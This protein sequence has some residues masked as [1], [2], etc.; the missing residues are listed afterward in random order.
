V[1]VLALGGQ[2]TQIGDTLVQRFLLLIGC[3]GLQHIVDDPVDHV[4]LGNATIDV[5]AFDLVVQ[6]TFH[7]TVHGHDTFTVGGLQLQSDILFFGLDQQQLTFGTPLLLLFGIDGIG[8]LLDAG[9][10][11]LLPVGFDFLEEELKV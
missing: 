4:L 10:T 8:Q 3:D 11:A 7:L 2:G 6:A 5:L 9:L 1:V